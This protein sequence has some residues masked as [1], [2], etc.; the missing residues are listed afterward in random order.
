MNCALSTSRRLSTW[1]GRRSAYRQV[2]DPFNATDVDGNCSN[3]FQYIQ[4]YLDLS[5]NHIHYSKFM[6]LGPRWK[7]LLLED[8]RTE[9][10][11]FKAHATALSKG[12]SCPEARKVPQK[13]RKDCLRMKLQFQVQL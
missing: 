9:A 10:L 3:M 11:P 12:D 8:G 2:L 6:S 5:W 4:F 13:T 7:V 1:E